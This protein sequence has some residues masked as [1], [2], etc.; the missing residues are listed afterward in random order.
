MRT[1]ANEGR[2]EHL[3]KE[4]HDNVLAHRI[5]THLDLLLRTGHCRGNLAKGCATFQKCPMS[6]SL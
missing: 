5:N 3:S 1:L 4:L 2:V 6:F